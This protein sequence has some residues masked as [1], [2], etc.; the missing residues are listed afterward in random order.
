MK[1]SA[2]KKLLSVLLGIILITGYA[3]AAD[4]FITSHTTHPVLQAKT[5]ASPHS[6]Y[7]IAK[8]HYL[9]DYQHQIAGDVGDNKQNRVNETDSNRTK[10]CEDVGYFSSPKGSGYNCSKTY[11]IHKLCYACTA[12]PCPSGY[13]TE[14]QKVGDCGS[15]GSEGWN[16]NTNGYSGDEI[17]SKCSPKA[18][19]SDYTT[20]HQKV[21]DCGSKGSEGWNFNTN[22]YSGDKICSKCS[23][24]SCP[25]GYSAGISE[26]NGSGYKYNSSGYSGDEICGICPEIPCATGTV[27]QS[28]CEGNGGVLTPNGYLSGNEN[29]G[30]CRYLQPSGISDDASIRNTSLFD[31]KA[32]TQAMINQIGADALAATACNQFYA[33][34]VDKN[35]ANFG[36]G[37]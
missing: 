5:S 2:M 10:S 7:E 8:T 1:V 14:H 17:C 33:P 28:E 30:S 29:C 35:D 3:L 26:C 16:F 37:N 6:S 20:E 9:P 34:G 27:K 22:G 23:P 24:K 32:N 13:T 18:C 15:K 12:K 19:A 21:G 36:Q 25:A 4:N 11:S 31:G